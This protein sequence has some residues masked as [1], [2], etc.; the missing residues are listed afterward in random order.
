MDGICRMRVMGPWTLS[1]SI[2]TYQCTSSATL[3]VPLGW[4]ASWQRTL[5]FHHPLLHLLA[6]CIL[7]DTWEPWLWA[8]LGQAWDKVG[9]NW[10]G[11]FLVFEVF[12]QIMLIQLA[13]LVAYNFGQGQWW[14]MGIGGIWTE[15]CRTTHHGW[16]V[17]HWEA[18]GGSNHYCSY[19][20]GSSWTSWFFSVWWHHCS[21]IWNPCQATSTSWSSWTC[22]ATWLSW[23]YQ[24]QRTQNPQLK[25]D[26]MAWIT[27]KFGLMV[28]DSTPIHLWGPWELRVTLWV[29]AKLEARASTWNDFGIIFKLKN[30]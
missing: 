8:E 6:R 18:R 24:L 22:R 19:L 17:Q 2:G 30:C 9:F 12:L 3:F 11:M 13:V 7:Q 10:V 5:T 16:T 1:E 27:M 28:L 26:K 25:Q 4:Y 23:W 29:L 14:W 21:T 20:H 15:H